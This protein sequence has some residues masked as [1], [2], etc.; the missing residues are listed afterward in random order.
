VA[1]LPFK[2]AV[3]SI[4]PHTLS[5]RAVDYPKLGEELLVPRGVGLLTC[6]IDVQSA[7][8]GWLDVSIWG[9]GAQER[10]WVYKWIQLDGDPG[11]VRCVEASSRRRHR[12]VSASGRRD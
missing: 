4:A 9:W 1:G 7:H 5:S 10:A 11:P 8:G 12:A 3:E 6:F 2:E